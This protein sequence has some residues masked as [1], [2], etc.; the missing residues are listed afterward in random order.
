VP[1]VG[2]DTE[3]TFSMS[4]WRSPVACRWAGVR[5]VGSGTG[6]QVTPALLVAMMT[7]ELSSIPAA[8]HSV[9]VGHEIETSDAGG[10]PMKPVS[11]QV[12]PPSVLASASLGP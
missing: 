12:R 4:S 1:D 9:V 3:D 11:D 6:V 10:E 7:P 8:Q 5:A 2:Q